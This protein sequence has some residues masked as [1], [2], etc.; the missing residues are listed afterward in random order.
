M[1]VESSSHCAD[2]V[3]LFSKNPTVAPL[4]TNKDS[5]TSGQSKS[6]LE[7]WK[8]VI[9]DFFYQIWNYVKPYLC[10]EWMQA[11]EKAI[12]LKKEIETFK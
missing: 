5:L 4:K 10:F 1:R 3:N 8:D 7:E 11:D 9:V 2:R 6:T 12:S